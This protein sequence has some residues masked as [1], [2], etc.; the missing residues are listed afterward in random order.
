[1]RLVV[2][3]DTKVVAFACS[4]GAAFMNRVSEKIVKHCRKVHALLYIII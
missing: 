4:L 2:R 1:M 3:I